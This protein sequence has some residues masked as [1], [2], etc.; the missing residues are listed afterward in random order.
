MCS[1]TIIDD[2]RFTPKFTI[3]CMYLQRYKPTIK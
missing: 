3:V 1:S 2:L